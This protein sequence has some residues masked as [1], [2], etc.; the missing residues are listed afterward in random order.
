MGK[1]AQNPAR[2]PAPT[3]RTNTLKTREQSKVYWLRLFLFE[4]KQ[5]IG[6]AAWLLPY[7]VNTTKSSYRSRPIRTLFDW[8]D[9]SWDIKRAIG[10]YLND[11]WNKKLNAHDYGDWKNNRHFQQA[12]PPSPF[13]LTIR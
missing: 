6:R 12:Q 10:F 13:A 11:G 4:N 1:H 9:P 7:M 5:L 3:K 2:T 8:I